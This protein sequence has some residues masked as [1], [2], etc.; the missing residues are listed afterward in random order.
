M[1][2]SEMSPMRQTE[3]IDDPGQFEGFDFDQLDELIASGIGQ[4]A[5]AVLDLTSD[6]D[7]AVIDLRDEPT[8]K[9]R[10]A[11]PFPRIS[12]L[13]AEEPALAEQ[14]AESDQ[15]KEP[16]E[17]AA[18]TQSAE[19]AEMAAPTE[20]NTK[21]RTMRE[22]I[23]DKASE[24]WQKPRRVKAAWAVG[25]MAIAIA[26]PGIINDAG[27]RQ[28]AY[29]AAQAAKD[30]PASV[31]FENADSRTSTPSSV[32]IGTATAQERGGEQ[33]IGTV[34]PSASVSESNPLHGMDIDT[35]KYLY[36]I[37]ISDEFARMSATAYLSPE[38]FKQA[39]DFSWQLDQSQK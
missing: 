14:T 37:V 17:I 28:E 10:R 7:E 26:I 36:N 15:H 1:T 39:A 35:T 19:A 12:S 23:T 16:A 38:Q 4:P 33:T 6:D 27:E 31:A 9:A 32:D 8:I 3:V 2:S 30:T 25:A 11:R 24:F 29:A 13:T 21:R 34:T 22:F 5:E 18:V 20:A